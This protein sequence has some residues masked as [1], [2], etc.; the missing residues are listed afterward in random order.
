[1]FCRPDVLP[2][3]ESTVSK[4]WRSGYRDDELSPKNCVW[5]HWDPDK[6]LPASRF[7]SGYNCSCIPDKLGKY[8]YLSPWTATARHKRLF[9]SDNDVIIWTLWMTDAAVEKRRRTRAKLRY[10]EVVSD[11]VAPPGG[12]YFV[13]Q[14][15]DELIYEVNAEHVSV[16][17]G[18]MKR[19]ME[20]ATELSVKLPVKLK[21]GPAWG[22]MTDLELWPFIDFLAR[23]YIHAVRVLPLLGPVFLW[24]AAAW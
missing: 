12:G 6:S 17:A 18:I 13:L 14:L 1:M 4:H 15:H 9:I 19:C 8:V 7:A 24:A 21:A 5:F 20:S 22:T 16:V 3:T 2:V 23:C 11:S 10:S